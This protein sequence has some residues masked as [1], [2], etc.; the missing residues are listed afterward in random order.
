M[1]GA[2]QGDR[3]ECDSR[4]CPSGSRQSCR[5]R[6]VQR[7]P[8]RSTAARDGGDP[9]QRARRWR[10]RTW[11]RGLRPRC[12]W[13]PDRDAERPGVA[14]SRSDHRRCGAAQATRGLP[15]PLH[16][17]CRLI[18]FGPDWVDQYRPAAGYVDRILK[19]ERPTDLPVQAPTKY[20]LVINLKTAKALGL[21]LSPTLIARA[22]EMIE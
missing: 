2:P 19:G 4:S 1:A 12:E 7:D 22:T 6:S 18:S 10:D 8:S 9:R 20:E 13:R 11:R 17:H 3:A 14:S 16:G 15:F 5:D 21:T